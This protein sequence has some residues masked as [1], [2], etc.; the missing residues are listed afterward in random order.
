MGIFGPNPP[1]RVTP[2]EF[3]RKVLPQ[4]YANSFSTRER[5][6]VEKIFQADLDEERDIEIGI[7]S[8]ELERRV[9]WLRGNLGKHELSEEKIEKL[10]EILRNFI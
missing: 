9:Q 3:E 4:L 10:E 7:D 5:N 8:G 6:E 1:P 2:R